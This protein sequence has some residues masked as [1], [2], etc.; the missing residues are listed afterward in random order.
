MMAKDP[1]QRYQTPQAVARVLTPWAQGPVALPD[2]EDLPRI[3]PALSNQ[4][5]Q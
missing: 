2:A 3:S 5:G 1:E 4:P